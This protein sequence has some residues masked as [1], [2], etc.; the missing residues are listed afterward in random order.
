MRAAARA[1]ARD[2]PDAAA[3]GVRS[4]VAGLAVALQAALLL[5]HAPEPVGR[6]FV[7]ARLGEE[8]GSLYG[9]LPAAARAAIPTLVARA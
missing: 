7:D 6:A 3:A 8:R 5:R 9:E 2:R 1:I 4:F